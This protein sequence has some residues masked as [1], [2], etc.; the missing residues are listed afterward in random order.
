MQKKKYQPVGKGMVPSTTEA[1]SFLRSRRLELGIT[2]EE[3]AQRAGMSQGHYSSLETGNLKHDS[4]H[5]N[6][7]NLAGALRCDPSELQTF[8]PPDPQPQTILGKLI[9]GRREELGFTIEDVATRAGLDVVN[10]KRLELGDRGT[11]KYSTARALARTLHLDIRTLSDFIFVAGRTAPETESPLGR[12]IRAR[13]RE[14]GMTIRDLA[15]ALRTSQQMISYIERGVIPLSQSDRWFDMLAAALGLDA[16]YLRSMRPAKRRIKATKKASVDPNSLAAFIF[17]RRLEL[18]M[19]QKEVAKYAGVGSEAI[20]RI[21][22]GNVPRILCGTDFWNRLGKALACDIPQ[23]LIPPAPEGPPRE[24]RVGHGTERRGLRAGMHV[25]SKTALGAFLA[26]RRAAL[27][28][29]R[30]EASFKAGIGPVHLYEIESGKIKRPHRAVLEKLAGAL[31]C[32]VAALQELIPYAALSVPV[33]PQKIPVSDRD[34]KAE[35]LDRIQ[36]LAGI[37]RVDA[38][39]KGVQLLRRLL[40]RQR[41]GFSL[42]F[43]KE[44]ELVELE[45][46]L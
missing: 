16:A 44:G 22:T 25:E 32:D 23:V 35:D 20:W 29:P 27:G 3:A 21:E 34:P 19:T 14:L 28:M 5:N 15:D 42:F 24:T 36:E 39:R 43:A 17:R 30:R 8:I 45:L 31:Q 10:I 11:I 6:L 4:L 18:R 46:L 26:R 9:R 7:D 33:S 2:Q 37:E 1:G 38:E 40:E 12:V 41:N 13:R